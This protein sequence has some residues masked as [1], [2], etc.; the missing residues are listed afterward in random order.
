MRLWKTLVSARGAAVQR[1]IWEAH[2]TRKFESSKTGEQQALLERSRA[3]REHSR[4]TIAQLTELF[5]SLRTSIR[6]AKSLV[7]RS[8]AL[9]QTNSRIYRPLARCA[10]LFS[11]SIR[12]VMPT[13]HCHVSARRPRV[14][15]TLL[16]DTI[17]GAD[18]YRSIPLSRAAAP[19][20]VIH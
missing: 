10:D 17:W 2:S 6:E 1:T 3:L 11:I 19:H 15:S 14:A 18:L 16:P 20:R 9:Y 8:R 13:V 7:E 12:N 4:T 5:A